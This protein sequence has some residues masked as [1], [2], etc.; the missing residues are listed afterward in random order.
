MNND[1]YYIE[2]HKLIYHLDRVLDWLNN[3][4]IYPI[5]IEIA[6]TGVCNH[7]CIFCALDY[8]NYKPN[9]LEKDILKKFLY[10]ISKANVKSIMFAG[11][12]EPLLHKD[13]DFFVNY[14][15]KC[16]LDVAITTNGV[17]LDK[18][19]EKI[20]PD[21]E[22]IRVSLNAGK[23]TTYSKIHRTKKEDF[24]KVINNLFYAVKLK[25]KNKYNTTIG[26]QF[27]LLNENYKEIFMLIDILKDIGVDYLIIK[28][29]SQHPYSINRLEDKLY[30]DRFLKLEKEI[31]NY[32]KKNLEV[33]FRK[34]TLLKMEGDRLYKKCFGLVFW[35]YLASNGDLYACSSFLNDKRFL[36]GNIYKEDFKS[37]WH[38]KKKKK[39]LKMMKKF[40]IYNC[41]KACRLDEINKYLWMLKNPPQHVNFI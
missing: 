25:E 19:V 8:L 18:F 28:P 23:N 32:P 9:F 7:R 6:P 30:Y 40:N 16:N 34:N 26:V 11:E 33:I 15:K 39:I 27:L 10:D 21:L 3:K 1:K 38:G 37:I 5:Y 4:D 36:Y 35:A 20:L 24:D 12:G 2:S 14:A 31:E 29:Y 22:W 17:F 41:R 13:I